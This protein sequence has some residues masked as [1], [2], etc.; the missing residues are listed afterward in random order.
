M[1]LLVRHAHAGDRGAWVGDDALRP[2]SVRGRHQAEVLA[3]RL[4]AL[5]GNGGSDAAPTPVMRSSPALRCQATVEPLAARL[6]VPLLEDPA[7]FEGAAVAPLL[8]R[9]EA[10]T[11][12]EVWSS[13]GDVIP[14]LLTRL[15]E[16][17]V[18]LGPDPRCRK[19]SVWAL[20]VA[21]GRVVQAQGHEPPV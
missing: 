3:E 18:D 10:L 14:A 2:L 21:D 5:L 12:D 16:D 15:A 1:L 17:G 7:L 20:T 19:G 6:G 13:H 4:T 8:A 11:D 9:I